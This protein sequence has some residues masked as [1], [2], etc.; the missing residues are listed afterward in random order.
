MY[1]IIDLRFL[2]A[3]LLGYIPNRQNDDDTFLQ[4]YREE[5][6]LFYVD[7]PQRSVMLPTYFANKL[8]CKS[9]NRK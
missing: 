7:S 6:K 2:I 9:T 3:Y 1:V 5:A 4:S 8:S